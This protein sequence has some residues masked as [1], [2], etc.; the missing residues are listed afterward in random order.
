MWVDYRGSLS[1]VYNDGE[2]STCGGLTGDEVLTCA[3]KKNPRS[4][5]GTGILKKRRIQEK[6]TTAIPEGREQ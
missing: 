6:N 1:T 4:S 3:N 5:L 2:I